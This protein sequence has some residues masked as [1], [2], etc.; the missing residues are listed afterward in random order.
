MKFIVRDEGDVCVL[1][2][3]LK[4]LDADNS[5][6]FKLSFRDVVAGKSKVV[7]DLSNL[8]FVDSSGLGALLSCLRTQTG[9]EGTLKL[10]AMTKTVRAMFEL[11]RMHRVFEVYNTPD[12]AVRSHD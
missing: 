6:D 9:Q 2:V 1:E 10:C 11:V 12:E 5:K 3:P 8:D 4:Q 7:L